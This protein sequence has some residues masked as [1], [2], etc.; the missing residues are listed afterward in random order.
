MKFRW[1]STPAPVGRDD[2][3]DTAYSPTGGL[4]GGERLF[5]NIGDNVCFVAEPEVVTQ[6]LTEALD[7]CERALKQRRRWW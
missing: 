3:V 2:P 6:K 4:Y 7:E 5:V 1:E